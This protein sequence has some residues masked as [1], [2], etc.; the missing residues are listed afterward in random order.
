MKKTQLK[1]VEF[2]SAI[3]TKVPDALAD[4]LSVDIRRIIQSPEFVDA[5]AAQ[6]MTPVASKSRG[7]GQYIAAE[8]QRWDR[9]ILKAD[10]VAD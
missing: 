7:G 3:N 9:V 2:C 6:G 4:R 10:L 5:L 8:K 1:G